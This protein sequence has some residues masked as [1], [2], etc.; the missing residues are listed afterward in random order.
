MSGVLSMSDRQIKVSP[1]QYVNS[2]G[3]GEHGIIFYTSKEEMRDIHFAFVKSGLENN[4]AVIYA[5]PGSYTEELR[6]AMQNY[7]IDTKRHEEDAVFL[8]KKERMYI[9]ILQNL[10]SIILKRKPMKL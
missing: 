6:N 1:N 5:A 9:G 8:Y 3:A 2:L 4:W 10:T 7:G